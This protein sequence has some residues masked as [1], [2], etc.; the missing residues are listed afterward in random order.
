A[1][2]GPPGPNASTDIYDGVVTHVTFNGRIFI[3]ELAS[4]RPPQAAIHWRTTRRLQCPNLVG[5]VKL[6][7]KHASLQLESPVIWGE[8]T[9]HYDSRVSREDLKRQEGK[10]AVSVLSDDLAGEQKELDLQ[11]GDRIA[12]IDCQTFVPEYFP[13]LK[14]LEALNDMPLP[15]RDGQLL[16]LSSTP[17]ITEISEN[18]ADASGADA[19]SAMLAAGGTGLDVDEHV[20]RAGIRGLL[21][22]SDL[23]PI[24]Q[25]RREVSVKQELIEELTHLA[26][27]STMDRGQFNS[28]IGALQHPVHCTQDTTS[29]TG[30]SYVGVIIVRALMRIRD[31]WIKVNPSVGRPPIL[32]L[33]YKNHAIDEFLCDLLAA[34][35]SGRFGARPKM[36]RIGGSC[37]D[38]RLQPYTEGTVMRNQQEV[39]QS[40]QSLEDV[41][42][43]ISTVKE[44]RALLSEI[45][46][47]KADMLSTTGTEAERKDSRKAGYDA[48]EGVRK[49]VGWI[50]RMTAT[51]SDFWDTYRKADGDIPFVPALENIDSAIVAIEAKQQRAV[52][53]EDLGALYPG[54]RH[55]DPMVPE[56][57][58]TLGGGASKAN[59]E[60]LAPMVDDDTGADDEPRVCT[61]TTKKGKPCKGKAMLNSKYCFDHYEN[62]APDLWDTPENVQLRQEGILESG[63]TMSSDAVIGG[64]SPKDSPSETVSSDNGLVDVEKIALEDLRNLEFDDDADTVEDTEWHVDNADEVEE[65]EHLQHMRDVFQ[66]QE[67]HDDVVEQLSEDIAIEAVAMLDSA[68]RGIACIP[69]FEWNWDMSTEERWKACVSAIDL[70]IQLCA[71]VVQALVAELGMRRKAYH[72]ARVRANARVYEGQAVIGGT[73]VGCVTRLSAIRSTNPFAILVEE[74]S[75]VLEPLL[76]ACLGSTTCKLEM[77]GDHLQ[78][79][80]NVMNRFDFEKINK[81]QV[82]MFE[83]LITAPEGH[84]VPKSVLAVQ[85]RMRKSIAD[86]TRDFYEKIT[87]IV[88]H[89]RCHT[90]KIGDKVKFNLGNL[91]SINRTETCGR[92]V[93]G[94]QSHVFF[95]THS[96]VQERASVGLSKVNSAEA[97]MVCKLVEYFVKCG[98]PKQSIAILTPYKG[99]LMLL[100][101]TLPASIFA[102]KQPRDSCT[103][104]TV[105]RFQG[106]EADVIIISLV[107]DSKSRTPFVKF[108]NRMVVLLSRARLGMYILGN[109]DYFG[110][111]P[112]PHWRK[113]LHSL[114]TP[115]PEPTVLEGEDS[116]QNFLGPRIGTELPLCCPIHR[117]QSVSSAKSAKELSLSFYQLVCDAELTSTIASGLQIVARWDFESATLP[118]NLQPSREGELHR[119]VQFLPQSTSVPGISPFVGIEY[120]KQ[121]SPLCECNEV[122]LLLSLEFQHLRMHDD[123]HSCLDAYID[124]LRERD[125]PAHPLILVALARVLADAHHSETIIELLR[126][127]ADL[128]SGAEKFLSSDEKALLRTT[129]RSSQMATRVADPTPAE[130]W[131]ELKTR[132]GCKSTAMDKLLTLTGLKKVKLAAVHLFI[133]AIKFKKLSLAAQKANSLTLNYCFLGN[134]GTGKTTVARLFAEILHDSKLRPKSTFTECTA[135]QLKDDGPEKFRKLVQGANGGVLFIDEAYDLDPAGDFKGK[136]IVS[137]LLTV[138]ENMR[139][140]LSIILAG[141]E[142]NMNQKLFSWN[143]GLKSRFDGIAF[144]DFDE[145]D[146][147]TVWNEMV[148]ERHWKAEATV[149]KILVRKLAPLANRKGFGNARDVRK[150]LDDAIKRA[151]ARDDFEGHDLELRLVDVIGD[152]PM[153]NPKLL[154]VLAEFETKTGWKSI[155]ESVNELVTVCQ[156]NYER[157]LEG[158]EAVAVSLNKLFL[159][160]PG[161][162]KTTCA[163]LYGRL[164]KHL[165]F[166]SSGEVLVKTA[167][168]FVGSVVG[169]S[170]TKTCAILEQARG[171]VLLID[172]AYNLDDSMYGKQV[173]DVL[174][175]KVSG[176]VSDDMAVLLVGYTEPM[177]A[178][179]RNQNDGLARRFPREYAFNFED[180]NDAEL[181]GIF[182]DAC[183]EKG[184]HPSYEV[185]KGATQI[186]GMQQRSMPNFGN[187]GAVHTLLAN[188]IAKATG[189]QAGAGSI[190]LTPEDLE[191]GQQN[192]NQNSQSD[193]LAPLDALYRM[194]NVK[195]E[196]AQLRDA[197]LVAEREGTLGPKVGHF[198]FRGPPG[199]G[200]TTV[201]RVCAQILHGLGIIGVDKVVETSGLN[202]QGEYLG[203]TKK[204]VE[205]RLGEAKGG[206][207]F[208]DE[209]SSLGEGHYGAEAMTTLV[210]AMTNPV[211]AG[212]VIIIAG[213]P[214]DIDE[215]LNRN[216]GLKSR[217]TRFI[218]FEGWT[219]EDALAFMAKLMEKENYL[220]EEGVL[221]E[222]RDGFDELRVPKVQGW[223]SG[224]DV[225]KVWDDILKHRAARVINAPETEKTITVEDA[226]N[227]MEEILSSRRPPDGP[228]LCQPFIPAG[229][230]APEPTPPRFVNAPSVHR[231]S[232]QSQASRIVEIDEERKEREEEIKEDTTS[233]GRD[234]GVSDED[235]EELEKAKAEYTEKMDHILHEMNEEARKEELRKQQGFRRRYDVSV[236]ARPVSHGSK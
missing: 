7:E 188:A 232:Q 215:M 30:K 121:I 233:S 189:R 182:Q 166:L 120:L 176:S 69:P 86:L 62:G 231:R 95:W 81:I 174:V 96:G 40:Q 19:A 112:V 162:G 123:A 114:R 45:E 5:I 70:G 16:N 76:F 23:D 190:V 42:Y 204:C 201:A 168:D 48:A 178:M 235:W 132:E 219:T 61:A 55:L 57:S 133:S 85:R 148:A 89:P 185:C 224:R 51:T 36:I 125:A 59:F 35:Q 83:R 122:D 106:D 203:Q 34:E 88:D 179:L 212:V 101:K 147:L 138:S 217:F 186:L 90:Q 161:T 152:N 154:Q 234:A 33:S 151:M 79:Q 149:G 56:E 192:T 18:V 116:V 222:L 75:E 60:I 193:R 128:G 21:E 159:G 84:L 230:P 146:L 165:N 58:R 26:M 47:A 66:V 223:G 175:E 25:I 139:H 94:V 54:I 169:E 78:L 158:Q 115:F 50:M 3:N 143:E 14:A 134:P 28:F 164:L 32:V 200:K 113:T 46:C 202:L 156:K 227:A 15:F 74:A 37:N 141:Y 82:S 31:L 136:P 157:E 68:T 22:N 170:Q 172:E 198:V 99:Q 226:E 20:A 153:D 108:Q 27:A 216:A 4:R 127:F 220:A 184:I 160:N 196:L 126:T 100:R 6:S 177:L 41:H 65:S 38:P 98:V 211:Y 236:L 118:G 24:V 71:K 142:E 119:K 207:L 137:E 107:I 131:E 102:N 1:L 72:F 140:E 194:D 49:L 39:R 163:K 11:K 205:E 43:K 228:L 195:K 144:E 117:T 93:P 111:K 105:D 208:I 210:E 229:M 12:I 218:D 97:T 80:P 213:Y 67:E 129:G 13:V 124:K 173:L 150:R 103:I 17:S 221:D 44:F 155:K 171:K 214:R 110:D 209:A 180:Y 87:P 53:Q 77:I 130:L 206:I 135:Q 225:M 92:E 191:V 29:G 10:M 2:R 187:A 64:A 8:I 91:A 73:I 199:T 63:P 145:L 52:K 183:K 104:S 181:L 197:F 167:S 9:S 109:V